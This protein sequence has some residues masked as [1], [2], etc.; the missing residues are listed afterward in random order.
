MGHSRQNVPMSTVSF[1]EVGR[2]VR[3]GEWS[4][5]ST[6]IHRSFDD[7]NPVITALLGVRRGVNLLVKGRQGD[8]NIDVEAWV[9]EPGDSDGLAVVTDED[10]TLLGTAAIPLHSGCGDRGC[11][12]NGVQLCATVPAGELPSL[13]EKLRQLPD[14]GELL[15]TWPRTWLSG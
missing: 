14:A 9:G 4:L 2:K 15:P 6:W 5:H 8:A 10:G 3:V 13:V 11:S 7:D 1:D 12:N